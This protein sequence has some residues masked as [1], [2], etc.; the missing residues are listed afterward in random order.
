MI[1]YCNAAAAHVTAAALRTLDLHAEAD[2]EYG[3]VAS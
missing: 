1:F 2:Q 3:A